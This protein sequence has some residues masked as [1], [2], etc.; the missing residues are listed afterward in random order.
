MNIGI[1]GL[2]LIGG[3]FAK[4]LSSYTTHK[5]YVGDLDS[6][7]TAQA[8]TDGVANEILT[9]ENLAQCDM[10]IIALY[11]QAVIDFCAA[12]INWFK[13]GAL[14]I[15]CAGVKKTICEKL[16]PLLKQ[17]HVKFIGGHPM[18]GIE[19]SGYANATEKLFNGA[20]M[21]LCTDEQDENLPMLRELFLSIGFA[22]LPLTTPEIHDK[23]IAYTSQ[24]AHLVSN[25]FIKSETAR[26]HHD[27]SAGSYR[28][29]TRV[30]KLNENLWTE[31]FLANRDALLFETDTLIAELQKY[32]NALFTNNA[33][34]LRELLK[35]G[36]VLKE[37]DASVARLTASTQA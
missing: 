1:V 14:V 29:L 5:I 2:G 12:K 32:R 31:L 24:L 30:A 22:R 27:F 28:D 23:I 26:Q 33:T 35:S 4:A 16:T 6:S 7:V 20:A 11:P 37:Q 15:D 9:D 19:K 18:A 3:S 13:R 25:A 36:R 10:V 34:Q 21:I 8:I 17:H